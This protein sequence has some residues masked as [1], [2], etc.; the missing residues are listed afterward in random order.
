MTC[1]SEMKIS[2][3]QREK[4]LELEIKNE[5]IT[6]LKEEL[7]KLQNSAPSLSSSENNSNFVDSVVRILLFISVLFLILLESHIYDLLLE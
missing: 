6:R 5:T 4:N 1:T 3:I 7:K 2:K